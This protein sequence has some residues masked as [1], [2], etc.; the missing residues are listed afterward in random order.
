M[1]KLG[2]GCLLGL[3][4]V[5]IMTGALF[6][7]PQ[8]AVLEPKE[9]RLNKETNNLNVL[10]VGVDREKLKMIALYTIDHEVS[11]RSAAIFIPIKTAVGNAVKTALLQDIYSQEGV[12]G[13]VK[14]LE[15]QLEVNISYY[16]KV[17]KAVLVKVAAII[18]PIYA[19]G[20]PVDIA[21]LF[22]MAV[23]PYDDYI[24]GE[25]VKEFSK[26][27]VFFLALPEIFFSFRKHISTDFAITP[28]NLY[29]HYK[30]A[31]GIKPSLLKKTIITGYDYY[32]RGKWMRVIPEDTWKRIV[33]RLTRE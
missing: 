16:I 9:E 20:Q 22:D 15:E 11:W 29:L 3:I 6:A 14:V 18:D 25:L 32:D 28:S 27:A 17:D 23:T 33:Y 30:I 2:K 24:L 21:N 13:V 19:A 12:A 5:A 26:P 10:F 8:S 4:I 31:T 7:A 1:G